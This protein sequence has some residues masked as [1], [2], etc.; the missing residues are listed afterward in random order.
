[1]SRSNW[2]VRALKAALR[3]MLAG[4][5]MSTVWTAAPQAQVQAAS[6]DS[7]RVALFLDLGSKYKSTVPAVTISSQEALTAS[8]VTPN[9]NI[10][11]AALNAGEQTR[12]SSNSYRVKVMESK[13]WTVIAEAVKKL[14][15]TVDKP[16]VFS[17][18]TEQG[19]VYQLYTGMYASEQAAKEAAARTALAAA[20]YLKGQIPSAK[21]SMHLTTGPLASEAD[22]EAMVRALQ[23]NGVDAFK[24]IV[25]AG[26][27]VSY[28]A[29]A[30]EAVNEAE[31]SALQSS[32]SKT[33]ITMVPTGNHPV[34]LILREDA[35]LDAAA[36]QSMVHYMISGPGSKLWLAGTGAGINVKERS[37]RTYRGSMEA[38][39]K[40]GQL[41]LVNT[42]PF[43]QYLYSVVGAEVP[44]SWSMEALKAQAVAARSYA[45]YQGLRFEVAHVVDTV[46][47]QAYNG[48]SSEAERTT[49]AVN[50]TA[51][52]VLMSGGSIVEA[53][54]SSNS[55][56]VTADP[57]EV[58]N[59]GNNLF[60]AVESPG[61]ASAQAALKKWYAILLPSGQTGYVREDNV[62]ETGST[63]SG[64]KTMTVTAN[65]TNVRPLPM[66][67][68]S[69]QPLTQMNPGQTAIVLD[70]VSESGSYDWVRG[71]FTSEQLLGSLKGRTSTSLPSVI[72]SLEVTGRGP[73]GRVT[74]L[75]LNGQAL[76]VSYPDMFRSA[77]GGLPSTMFDIEP[78]GSYTVLG[79]NGAASASSS[80][81]LTILGADQAKRPAA[82]GMIIMNG[83]GKSRALESGQG[84][85]FVGKGN[86]HGLGLS[87]WGAKGM[88]DEGYD[89][90]QI[91]QHYYRNTTIV[92]D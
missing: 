39:S 40:N 92:K 5:V 55:G 63:L 45:L 10:Q 60:A 71:P 32:V 49:A 7:I 14:Q 18:Y 85:R 70:I 22:A 1:M 29:W 30:G 79:A 64:L 19:K 17:S 76:K 74:E 51:G 67:Q 58:W 66:I 44:S 20:V 9:A 88:A 78:T 35:G 82:A 38:G 4:A 31:L 68:S 33:A 69:V 84:F 50:A 11:A 16:V 62:K 26:E 23:Y 83:A 53:V 41:Y 75:T 36:P 15:A 13:D 8:F 46:L 25:P 61:D 21:G 34:G 72:T 54:F 12:L 48:I 47:T 37:G 80:T 6:M 3:I 43:E 24:A 87:Q 86:G 89:Y 65:S 52:E 56:G 42:V 59:S 91:L 28:E 57:S 2:K 81:P 77:L 27:G 90:K 73:S